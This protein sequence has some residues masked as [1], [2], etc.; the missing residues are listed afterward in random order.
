[1]GNFMFNQYGIE[2]TTAVVSSNGETLKFLQ[3]GVYSSKESMEESMKGFNYY[4]YSVK[5][6]MYYVYI[7]ITKS[8][9]N[10]DKL[11]KHFKEKGYDIYAADIYIDDVQFIETLD[12]YEKVLKETTDTKTID[13]VC[14]QVLSKYEEQVLND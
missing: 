9:D 1:M 5:D 8:E 4:I 12:Q 14:S 11:K 2:D 10:L 7:G 3:A 13:A 6:N